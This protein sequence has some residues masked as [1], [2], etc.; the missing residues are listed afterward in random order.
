[1]ALTSR[2]T[3]S[4]DMPSEEYISPISHARSTTSMRAMGQ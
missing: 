3:R 2:S 4:D 1:M